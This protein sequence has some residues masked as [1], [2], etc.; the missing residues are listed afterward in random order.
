VVK[1]TTTT[2][3]ED[4][5][6][7]VILRFLYNKWKNPSGM[8]S[9]KPKINEIKKALK[10]KGIDHKQVIRNLQY[11]ID[12]GWVKEIVKTSTFRTPK[13]NLVNSESVSYMIG[14]QGIEHFDARS[15]FGKREA[16]AGIRIENVPGVVVIGNNNV[17]RQEFSNLF[18]SLDELNDKIKLTSELTDEQKVEYSYDV[19]TIQDQLAKPSPDKGILNKAWGALKFVGTIGSVAN[20]WEKVRTG[21]EQA[22]GSIPPPT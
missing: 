10:Q 12:T 7:E 19:R 8:S 11:L 15:K 1:R 14:S 13:G 5:V 16:A 22:F 21:L 4:D 9:A 2:F 17:V 3:T 6:R 18:K 20:V